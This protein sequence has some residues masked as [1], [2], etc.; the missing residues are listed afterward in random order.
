[1]SGSHRDYDHVGPLFGVPVQTS[2]TAPSDLDP[3]S[4]GVDELRAGLLAAAS[5]VGLWDWGATP[6]VRAMEAEG[7]LISVL[8]TD[9]I[10]GWR[11]TELG[12]LELSAMQ[13]PETP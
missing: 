12:R 11:I 4:F 6:A 5:V 7:W 8:E 2:S 10:R 9:T 3:M 1:M 13:E